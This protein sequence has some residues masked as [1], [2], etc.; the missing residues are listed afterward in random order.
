MED[1]QAAAEAPGEHMLKGVQLSSSAPNVPWGDREDASTSEAAPS[2]RSAPRS[3][4]H[5]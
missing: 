5:L 3:A 1:D 4:C 2:G